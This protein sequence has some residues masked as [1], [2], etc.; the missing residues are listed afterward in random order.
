MT[1]NKDFFNSWLVLFWWIGTWGLVD[2]LFRKFKFNIDSTILA[3]VIIMILSL[4][5]IYWINSS[6]R[7]PISTI[8]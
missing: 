5:G 1:I 2:V 6:F 4:F 7:H 3:Y 8:M